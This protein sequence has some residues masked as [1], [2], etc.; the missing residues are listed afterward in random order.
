MKE[1]LKDWERRFKIKYGRAPTKQDVIKNPVVFKLYQQYKRAKDEIIEPSPS[2]GGTTSSIFMSDMRPFIKRLDF[3]SP[4]RSIL[5]QI[6]EFFKPKK[7]P[8]GL[9]LNKSNSSTSNPT[10]GVSIEEDNVSELPVNLIVGQM[11]KDPIRTRPNPTPKKHGSTPLR[12][13]LTPIK[14]NI[15]KTPVKSTVQTPI[16]LNFQTTP[17]KRNIQTTPVKRTVQTTPVKITVRTTPANL[18]SHT[19]PVKS[20][21]QTTPV[22]KLST[23]TPVK[24]AAKT[25][26]ETSPFTTIQEEEISTSFNSP[27]VI[28]P[29]SFIKSRVHRRGLCNL[30]LV[31]DKSYTEFLTPEEVQK[32]A[33]VIQTLGEEDLSQNNQSHDSISIDSEAQQENIDKEIK[34]APQNVKKRSAK[35]STDNEKEPA[36]KKPRNT[37]TR[38]NSKTSKN[39]NFRALKM[40][41]TSSTKV[42]SGFRKIKQLEKY[43]DRP[44]YLE[45]GAGYD[46]EFH[47]LNT[48]ADEFMNENEPE[49]VKAD[50]VRY[51][52]SNEEE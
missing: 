44:A 15:Q 16:K 30:N 32:F 5:N 23:T 9:D 45:L 33:K 29:S 19:T 50:F 18:Y 43:N 40:K 3:E 17:I 4:R 48:N 47:A 49:T 8:F 51:K 24:N 39:D 12:N 34:I 13:S 21:A 7:L 26:L 6:P 2:K 20:N 41:K 1:Q 22:K 38:A 11:V 37:R 42:G 14:R 10:K 28:K 25:P 46:D 36:Q 31:P 52:S 35:Q 27:Q